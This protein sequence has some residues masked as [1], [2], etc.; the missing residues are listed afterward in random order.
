MIDTARRDKFQHTR[1]CKTSHNLIFTPSYPCF[2]L[3]GNI[4]E[5]IIY[6]NILKHGDNN[7]TS[8][9]LYNPLFN[10]PSPDPKTS[11]TLPLQLPALLPSTVNDNS[12][13]EELELET[14]TEPHQ[15]AKLNTNH[16]PHPAHNPLL[17]QEEMITKDL[18]GF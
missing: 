16:L 9:F 17:L 5:K 7:R 15:E 12:D 2:L 14:D 8:F 1:R 6:P 4:F 13:K 11:P 10:I 3:F 18:I